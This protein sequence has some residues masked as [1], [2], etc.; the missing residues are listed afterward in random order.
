MTPSPGAGVD[1]V[2]G[3]LLATTRLALIVVD[4]QNDFTNSKGLLGSEGADISHLT[5][6]VAPINGFA[7]QARQ[8]AVP[9]VFTKMAQEEE[10][11]SAAD[12]TL[13]TARGRGSRIAC[14]AGTWGAELNSH[15]AVLPGDKVVVKRRYSAFFGTDLD[16]F[17]RESGCG[18]V[19]L[20]GFTTDVCVGATARDAFMLDYHVLI[21]SDLTGT[22]APDDSADSLRLLAKHSAH[23][24]TSTQVETVWN[25][26][27]DK[28]AHR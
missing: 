21:A 2:I 1:G 3:E 8:H 11:S 4:V 20:C 19:L 13:R 5:R 27:N 10:H 22:V 6:L 26:E 12:R 7:G 9:V 15:V 17:L 14:S 24:C 23:L 18:G 16:R 28:E 25:S